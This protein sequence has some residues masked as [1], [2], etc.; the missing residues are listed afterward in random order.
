MRGK[1][2]KK[3]SRVWWLTPLIL[4]LSVLSS[5]SQWV[6]CVGSVSAWSTKWAPGQLELQSETLMTKRSKEK[7]GSVGGK[8]LCYNLACPVYRRSCSLMWYLSYTQAP[9]SG[10]LHLLLNDTCTAYKSWTAW[11]KGQPEELRV[12][13]GKASSQYLLHSSVLSLSLTEA[14]VS[15]G[16]NQ[17]FLIRVG[18][19]IFS[20]ILVSDEV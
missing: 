12:L 11:W 13:Q 16:V 8:S 10:W 5:G 9:A 6:Q 7:K 19:L 17:V 18:Y 15:R 2:K 20:W 3:K 14:M 4:A 1:E